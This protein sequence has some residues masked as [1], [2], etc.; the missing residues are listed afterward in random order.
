LQHLAS[1]DVQLSDFTAATL[2]TE[3]TSNR[4]K[5]EVTVL[6]YAN[7]TDRREMLI[8]KK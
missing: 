3:H 4:T 6:K 2:I 7:V 8:P 1:S 5:S